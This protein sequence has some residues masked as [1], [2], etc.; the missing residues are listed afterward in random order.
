[1]EIEL[2]SLIIVLI[3]FCIILASIFKMSSMQDDLTEEDWVKDAIKRAEEEE[4]KIKCS[5]K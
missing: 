1:M 3:F 2:I 4:R 5:K